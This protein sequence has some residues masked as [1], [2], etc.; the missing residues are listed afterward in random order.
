MT[1]FLLGR[2][3]DYCSEM[4]SVLSKVAALWSHA[5]AD[6]EVLRAVDQIENLTTGLARKIWQKMMILSEVRPTPGAD[7]S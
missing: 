3:L 1:N 5:S 2:Y 4:L 6:S 7:Q